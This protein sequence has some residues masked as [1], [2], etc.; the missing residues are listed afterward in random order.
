[1]TDA[2]C[3]LR[4]AGSS[5]RLHAFARGYGALA[6]QVTLR[7]AGSGGCWRMPGHRI[8]QKISRPPPKQE[9]KTQKR[10]GLTF[11]VQS[12]RLDIMP[13]KRG[14]AGHSSHPLY[15][16]AN[17]PRQ[18]NPPGS[19]SEHLLLLRE[20]DGRLIPAR[21]RHASRQTRGGGK[22]RAY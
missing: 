22:R 7:R 16:C 13:R 15:K 20:F 10:S 4:H 14:T 21:R 19:P 1:M 8:R 9:R 2:L 5:D 18:N 12:L 6:T 3:Q 17:K 11:P